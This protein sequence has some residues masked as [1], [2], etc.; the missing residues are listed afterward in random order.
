MEPELEE[1]EITPEEE[2]LFERV[3]PLSPLLVTRVLVPV[4]V[5]PTD[6]LLLLRVVTVD[7]DDD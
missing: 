3:V 4:D 7:P 5:F 1:R 6:S 2:L